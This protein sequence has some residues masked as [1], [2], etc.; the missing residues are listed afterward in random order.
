M[1]GGR[2]A[3]WMRPSPCGSNVY[4]YIKSINYIHFFRSVNLQRVERAENR[5][6]TARF[7]LGICWRENGNIQNRPVQ[8]RM[9]AGI[10][11]KAGRLYMDKEKDIVSIVDRQSA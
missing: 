11:R 2:N 6:I 1:A 5:Q 7:S 4:A 10:N 3:A 8:N 9:M